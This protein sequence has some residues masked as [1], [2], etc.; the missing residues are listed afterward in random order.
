MSLGAHSVSPLP[1]VRQPVPAQALGQS[2]GSHRHRLPRAQ[3]DKTA[4]FTV[5]PGDFRQQRPPSRSTRSR[6]G[7][8]FCVGTPGDPRE[9]ISFRSLWRQPFSVKAPAG[10]VAR[11]CVPSTTLF[12]HMI[13][14]GSSPVF[15]ASSTSIVCMGPEARLKQG[16]CL[17]MQTV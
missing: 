10:S 14:T 13:K 11:P 12:P 9:V 8:P 16:S 3:P 1:R 2:A 6:V 17:W 7:Q 4:T 5:N 15:P